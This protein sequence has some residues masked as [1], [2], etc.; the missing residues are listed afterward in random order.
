IISKVAPEVANWLP[1]IERPTGF[2]TLASENPAVIY[3][4]GDRGS[5]NRQIVSNEVYFWGDGGKM[6]WN[7]IPG[8]VNQD[9]MFYGDGSGAPEVD[10]FAAFMAVWEE[11]SLPGVFGTRESYMQ[12]DL[13]LD[14]R[15]DM[16]DAYLM[17]TYLI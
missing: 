13:N 16:H 5:N 17:R 12:G 7:G 11:K 8:D 14:G 6:P 2:N 9:G 15:V 4:S 3:L 10:D 1:S